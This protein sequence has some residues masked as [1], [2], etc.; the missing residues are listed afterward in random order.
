MLKAIEEPVNRI[1]AFCEGYEQMFDSCRVK[2]IDKRRWVEISTEHFVNECP[3]GETVADAI[4]KL[5]ALPAEN[6]NYH[7]IY[8]GFDNNE[9]SEVLIR[10]IYRIFPIRGESG[11]GLSILGPESR[12]WIDNELFVTKMLVGDPR[13]Q[14]LND[15]FYGFLNHLNTTSEEFDILIHDEGEG[16]YIRVVTDADSSAS[17]TALMA[18]TFNNVLFSVTPLMSDKKEIYRFTNDREC[19]I[20]RKHAA[21]FVPADTRESIVCAENS[22]YNMIID[23]YPY[24]KLECDT[25]QEAEQFLAGI[26]V[27]PKVGD[28]AVS[29]VS[30]YIDNPLDLILK[31]EPLA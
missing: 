14:F 17:L 12:G 8:V 6:D 19:R 2:V 10:D 28:V 15:L 25:K 24:A 27:D 22:I 20:W 26:K 7:V 4:A 29:I 31:E 30:R 3:E 1:A 16:V 11:V 9:E 21:V 5:L 18:G 23:D 13:A